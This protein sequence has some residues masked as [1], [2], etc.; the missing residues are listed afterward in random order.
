LLEFISV[1]GWLSD[2]DDDYIEDM[3]ILL[4]IIHK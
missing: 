4:R 2:D 1:Y 3:L